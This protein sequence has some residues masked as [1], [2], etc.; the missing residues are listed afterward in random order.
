MATKQQIKL[1]Q[2]AVRAAGLRKKNSEGRYRLLL[3]QYLEPD[4]SPCTSCRELNNA[5]VDDLL[6]ICESLG[7]HYPAKPKDWHQ[8]KAIESAGMISYAQR[9]AIEHLAGDL[10]WTPRA[11]ANFI[12]RQTSGR[13]AVITECTVKDGYNII[14]GLKNVLGR[15]TGRDYKHASLDEVREDFEE[16]V[17]KDAQTTVKN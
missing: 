9:A 5:Q 10:G 16:G 17:G 14:E 8:K 15:I 2:I 1:I 13:T 11:L 12:H 6:G 7:W 4:G 3:R